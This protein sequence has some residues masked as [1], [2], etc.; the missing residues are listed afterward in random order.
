MT[1][2]RLNRETCRSLLK[3]RVGDAI[4]SDDYEEIL[5]LCSEHGGYRT[6]HHH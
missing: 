4:S 1:R 2:I 6:V 3:L 5:R